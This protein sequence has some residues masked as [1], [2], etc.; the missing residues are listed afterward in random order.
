MAKISNLKLDSILLFT[1]LLHILNSH[2]IL[3]YQ[4][5]QIYFIDKKKKAQI[6][7]VIHPF[8]VTLPPKHTHTPTH[9]PPTLTT[10]LALNESISSFLFV[11]VF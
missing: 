2:V 8:A 5:S 11:F 10:V 9:R 1:K 7:Y 6:H 3:K 4:Y